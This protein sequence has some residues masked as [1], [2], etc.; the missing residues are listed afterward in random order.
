[1]LFYE[2]WPLMTFTVLSQLAI[3]T[4]LVLWFIYEMKPKSAESS[5][6]PA[7]MKK[8]LLAVVLIMGVSLLF[9][10]FHLGTPMGAYRSILNFTGSW[11]SREIIFAGV[12]FAMAAVTFYYYAKK[13]VFHRSVALITSLVGLVAVFSMASLYSASIR[14]AWDHSYT[15]ITFFGT[16]LLM[17]IM[18][19]VFIVSLGFKGQESLPMFQ[20]IVK[21]C[22]ILAAIIIIAQLAYLPVYLSSL[23]GGGSVSELSMQ[24]LTENYAIL[25]AVKWILAILGTMLLIYVMKSKKTSAW[26][27][28]IPLMAFL[29]VFAGEYIG[30]YVFYGIG[31]SIGIG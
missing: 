16:T 28:G 5:V 17:G 15:F 4:Y 7:V 30:R 6:S 10:L 11:L 2:E 14:P 3:G 24:L 31:V 1:M 19:A 29:L 20:G 27:S 18:G 23:S 21:K 25:F 13:Q 22:C 9:S 12:F 8:G 26:M